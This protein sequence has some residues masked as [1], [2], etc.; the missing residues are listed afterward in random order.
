MKRAYLDGD[1]NLFKGQFFSEWRDERHVIKPISI[2]YH[3]R[4]FG[5]LD[6]GRTNPFCFL[7][8]ALDEEGNVY[9]YREYYETGKDAQENARNV[10]R[11]NRGDKLEYIVADSSI[12]AKAGHS[13]SGMS[14]TIADELRRGGIG[15]TEEMGTVIRCSKDRIAG[16]TF[17][18]EYLSWDLSREPKLRFFEQCHNSI[19]T[20]PSLV[21]NEKHGN[22]EDLN[23]ESEDHAADT[24]RY[25]LQTLRERSTKP[26]LDNVER[27]L[28]QMKATMTVA[29]DFNKR[30]YQD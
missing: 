26:V 24:V 1:W 25:F 12:F 14:E 8:F 9:C 6:F 22:P 20:I 10:L 19:K 15:S 5:A 18:H 21:Y 27:K 11:F 16:W 13:K 29:T 23:S 28:E 7:W 17:M 30:F 3:W 4:K 2:P